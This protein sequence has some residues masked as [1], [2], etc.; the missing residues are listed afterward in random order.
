MLPS[1]PGLHNHIN[2]SEEQFFN[3]SGPSDSNDWEGS[4]ALQQEPFFYDPYPQHP[5]QYDAGVAPINPYASHSQL[6]QAPLALTSM[7]E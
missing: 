5:I 6:Y 2:D 7:R 4:S 1:L 3:V